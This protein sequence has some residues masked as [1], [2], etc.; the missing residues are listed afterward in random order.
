MLH[1]Q[2]VRA[3][4]RRSHQSCNDTIRTFS[5]TKIKKAEVELFVDD[6]PVKIEGIMAP[7]LYDF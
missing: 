3:A 4:V 7:I 5:H 1:R 6:V 2:L